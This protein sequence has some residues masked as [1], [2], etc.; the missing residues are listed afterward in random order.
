MRVILSAR[1]AAKDAVVTKNMRIASIMARKSRVEMVM[2]CRGGAD[3]LGP[4]ELA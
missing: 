2:C 1:A 3:E 4:V